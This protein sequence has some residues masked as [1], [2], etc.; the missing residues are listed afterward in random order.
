M[1]NWNFVENSKFKIIEK[2]KNLKKIYFFGILQELLHIFNDPLFQIF[3]IVV[4]SIQKTHLQ[5]HQ[6]SQK[7]V[8]EKP[9]RTKK[10]FLVL[11]DKFKYNKNH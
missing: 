1:L 2:F 9:H 11:Y 8:A 5:S 7:T 6:K 3:K 10:Y 4:R